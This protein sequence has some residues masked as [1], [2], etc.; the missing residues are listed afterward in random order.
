MLDFG[1]TPLGYCQDQPGNQINKAPGE[2]ILPNPL[3][4][5]HGPTVAN[6][7]RLLTIKGG[8]RLP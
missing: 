4:G 1:N 8:T 6:P 5:F 7:E 2:E 3:D